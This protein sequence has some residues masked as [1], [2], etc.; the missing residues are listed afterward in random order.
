M[1]P[2]LITYSRQMIR[3]SPLPDTHQDRD[4]VPVP[5]QRTNE[6][7]AVGG[8]QQQQQP[9]SRGQSEEKEDDIWPRRRKSE[10]VPY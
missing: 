1:V 5:I 8:Q 7:A 6:K 9:Q 4:W 2:G 10:F 3:D